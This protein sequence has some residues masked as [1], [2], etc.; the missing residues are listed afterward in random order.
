MRFSTRTE[1]GIRVMV[2]LG[3]SGGNGPVSLS[4]LA[5]RERL[6]LSYLEQIAG[7]LRRSGLIQSRMGSHGGYM[8]GR[9]PDSITMADVVTSLEGSLAPV[10]CLVQGSEAECVTEADACSAHSLWERLQD[11]IT[12]TLKSTSVADLMRTAE[13]SSLLG[14]PG[15]ALP[16]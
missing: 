16:A 13:T 10:S 4:D 6:P 5:D 2:R 8:L 12:T 15:E 7:Q 9:P 3:R 11:S 14:S 1:Y